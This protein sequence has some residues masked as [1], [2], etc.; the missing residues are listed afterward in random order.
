MRAMLALAY[1][2]GFRK[3]EL[4][5]L[6]VSDVDTMA[7]TIRLRTS[8]NEEPRQVNLTAETRGLLAASNRWQESG[9]CGIHSRERAC[10]GLS[11]DVGRG[12]KVCW[13]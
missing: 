12:N 7:G 5:T 4:L 2:F 6:R 9:R 13:V 11:R 3:A 1:S 8:K 10:S